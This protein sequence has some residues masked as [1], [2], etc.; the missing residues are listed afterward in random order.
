MLVAVLFC[1]VVAG[2]LVATHLSEPA[3]PPD[4]AALQT[5]RLAFEKQ[6]SGEE[7]KKAIRDEDLRLRTEYFA[8]RRRMKWGGYLLAVGLAVA[9]VCAQWYAAL[10]PKVPAPKSL[11]ERT[12]EDRW[13]RRRRRV[14]VS[15]GVLAA[16]LGVAFLGMIFSGTTVLPPEQEGVRGAAPPASEG[17]GF[18]ENWPCFRGP[19]GMGIGPPG[20]WPER[21]DATTGENILWKT[22]VPASGNSSPVIWGNRVFL[23]GGDAGKRE[24]F[25][26]DR[27]TGKL[28]WRR[29]VET[30]A[31]AAPEKG[32]GPV[33]PLE[34][35][36]YAAPTPTTDGKRV[37][38]FFATADI[39]AVDLDGNVVWV[40]NLGKPENAYGLASSLLLHKDLLMVQFDRGAAAEEGLSELL[41]LDPATGKTVWHTPRPVPN[42]WS[43]PIAA[44]TEAGAQLVTC[45][46]PWVIAY[47]AARGAELWRANV[48]VR[49]VAVSPV[50]AEG[51]VFVTNDNAKVT[52]IRANGHGD[53]T[54]THVVWTAEMGMSDA[55]SPVSDGKFFLQANS[56]GLVTCY[57]AQKGELLWEH[58]FSCSFWASPTVVASPTR[59]NKLVYLPGEDGKVYVFELARKVQWVAEANVGEPV[60]ASPAFA[61]SQIYIRGRNHLLCVGKGKP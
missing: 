43:T 20:D 45:A 55:S 26:F 4:S 60:L 24:V 50:F 31:E 23:T 41:A 5:L 59:A 54:E 35:T 10:E 36:G 7:I 9:V 38:V 30:P 40:R 56:S 28:L 53:V 8:Y 48:L 29:P 17:G 52:A 49:D 32:E 19:T 3:A 14:L 34:Q 22:T 57:D 11:A 44:Q 42:S 46:A 47:D 61:D 16:V 1:G 2:V 25:C 15:A 6:P 21:W 12:D 13:L 37:Y 39:A 18:K 51:I 58:Q 27:K 33:Q